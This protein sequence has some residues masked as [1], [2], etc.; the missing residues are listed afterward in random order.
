MP[1]TQ[2]PPPKP[3]NTPL[4]VWLLLGGL[5]LTFGSCGACGVGWIAPTPHGELRGSEL[6]FFALVMAVLAS[7]G[8]VLV[9][10]ALAMGINRHT[11]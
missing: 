7:V 4:W 5:A 2:D 10:L 1:I 9:L 8:F 6:A 11:R 3:D